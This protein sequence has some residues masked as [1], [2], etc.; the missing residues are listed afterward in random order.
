MPL[1]SLIQAQ[2]ISEGGLVMEDENVSVTSALVEHPPVE[3]SIAFRFDTADR[4]IV[5]SGD[6][7]YSESLIELA[8]GAD[9]LV[10]EPWKGDEAWRKITELPGLDRSGRERHSDRQGKALL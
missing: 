5:I 3:P 10:H 6:T 2:E 1:D 4:S 9:V 7:N 8:Q